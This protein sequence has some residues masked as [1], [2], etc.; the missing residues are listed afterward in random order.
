MWSII[1]ELEPKL[2]KSWGEVKNVCSSGL[3]HLSMQG[4]GSRRR[5]TSQT[6]WWNG[7]QVDRRGTQKHK[8]RNQQGDLDELTGTKWPAC[9]E[10]VA[11]LDSGGEVQTSAVKKRTSYAYSYTPMLLDLERIRLQQWAGP[12]TDIHRTV[13]SAWPKKPF[14]VSGTV[15]SWGLTQSHNESKRNIPVRASSRW[16]QTHPQ[17]QLPVV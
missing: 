5:M 3:V 16:Q 2:F 11:E 10:R 9:I 4:N 7:L 1:N 8:A 12:L 14:L 15:K 6:Y 17:L 13:T